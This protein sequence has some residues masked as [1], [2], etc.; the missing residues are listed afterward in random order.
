MKL[1]SLLALAGLALLNSACAT[2]MPNQAAQSSAARATVEAFEAALVKGDAA[3][4]SALLASDVL[5]YESGGQESSREEYAGHHMKGDMAFLAGSKREVLSRAEG[6]NAQQAWVSTRSRLTGR[7]GGK[8]IDV[9][10]TETM[11]LDN[12][13]QGWRIVHIHWSSR[14]AKPAGP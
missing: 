14:P 5:V 4:A 8:E 6:G 9:F 11:V 10:S 7:H 2:L 12:T 1:Q 3:A 13:A